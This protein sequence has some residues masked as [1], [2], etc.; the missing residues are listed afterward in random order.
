MM[1][2]LNS[3]PLRFLLGLAC[4]L[5][6]L[7][8]IACEPDYGN[9]LTSPKDL[10]PSVFA[11]LNTAADSQYVILQNPTPPSGSY[12][13]FLEKEYQ[14][15]R[16]AVVSLTDGAGDFVFHDKY[17]II[18][19]FHEDFVHDFVFVSAHRAQPRENYHLRVEIP[20]KGVYMAST[21][22]PG[23]VQILSH[24]AQDTLDVFKP[25]IVRWAASERAA[26]YRVMLRWTVIDSTQFK[27]GRSNKLD[28]LYFRN[29]LYVES[30]AEQVALLNLD[31]LTLHYK[32]PGAF[33]RQALG[34]DA[35]IFV[36]ALDAPAWL[37]RELNQRGQLY[38]GGPE[39]VR[40]MPGSYSNIENGRG[41]MSAVTTKTIHLILPPRKP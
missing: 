13:K 9:L 1:N 16:Q 33:P 18:S 28:T 22:A 24:R 26:G 37:A 2:V 4:R 40:A 27:F 11:F 32:S 15:Y 19:P 17:E 14:L 38:Y 8:F 36:E 10:P 21:T 34:N 23:D 7:A 25:L 6:S 12:A 5:F 31:Y 30:S 39:E 20:Q 3:K 29:H 35:T 41:L